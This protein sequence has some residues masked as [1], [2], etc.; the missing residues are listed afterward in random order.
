MRVI[1]TIIFWGI[2]VWLKV[3]GLVLKALCWAIQ[4]VDKNSRK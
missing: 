2:I 3:S 4:Q 1:G